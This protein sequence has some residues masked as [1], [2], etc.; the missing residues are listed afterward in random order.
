M[1]HRIALAAVFTDPEDAHF[2]KFRDHLRRSIGRSVID[3]YYLDWKPLRIHVRADLVQRRLDT[4]LLVVRR[5]NDAQVR[6]RHAGLRVLRD[7]RAEA[8]RTAPRCDRSVRR[9]RRTRSGAWRW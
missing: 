7:G 1:P 4:P 5:N 9:R 2:G 6:F 3:D 8:F